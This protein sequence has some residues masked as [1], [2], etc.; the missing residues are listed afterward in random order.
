M[1]GLFATIRP[2]LAVMGFYNFSTT[3]MDAVWSCG[4][5]VGAVLVTGFSANRLNPQ[6]LGSCAPEGGKGED[7]R[8]LRRAAGQV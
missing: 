2:L 3:I 8:A 6:L 7:E 4:E 1:G 5:S